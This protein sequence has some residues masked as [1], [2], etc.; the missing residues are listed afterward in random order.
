MV[1]WWSKGPKL[2]ATNGTIKLYV[3][4]KTYT[5]IIVFQFYNTT[6]CPLQNKRKRHCWSI[7]L[8]IYIISCG[9]SN[10]QSLWA[11]Q[12]SVH[13]P[14]QARECLFSIPI[15][16]STGT[17]PVLFHGRFPGLLPWWSS[18]GM[19]LTSHPHLVLRLSMRRAIPPLLPPCQ[20]WHVTFI[21]L[22]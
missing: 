8:L 20:S 4:L 9:Q 10:S 13:I 22:S 19:M 21:I 1:W 12:S 6:G 16:T 15:Q 3:R 18:W 11:G 17:Q 2:V 5:L 14:P 7:A